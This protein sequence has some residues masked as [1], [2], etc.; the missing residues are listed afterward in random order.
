MGKANIVKCQFSSKL[1]HKCNA[2]PITIPNRFILKW[3][4][5]ELGRVKKIMNRNAVE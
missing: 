1:I 4:I 3:V 2:I 5:M